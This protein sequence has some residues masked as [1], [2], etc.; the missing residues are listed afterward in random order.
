MSKAAGKAIEPFE[1]MGK[2][3]GDLGMSLPKY[4]PL[5]IPGGS[6]AGMNKVVD[7]AS[8][9]PAKAAEERAKDSTIG[10]MLGM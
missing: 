8:Y 1:A 2:K 5:P 7:H 6:I 10:K 3:I 4:T 9:L